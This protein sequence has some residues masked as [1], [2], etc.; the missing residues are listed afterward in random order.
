MT[1]VLLTGAGAVA[2]TRA[3]LMIS[4]GGWVSAA[5]TIDRQQR[6]R[7]PCLN[8]GFMVEGADNAFDNATKV[9]VHISLHRD[10][11]VGSVMAG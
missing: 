4:A 5:L 1:G 8:L 2:V 3:A 11:D 9:D 6:L 7:D 10:L